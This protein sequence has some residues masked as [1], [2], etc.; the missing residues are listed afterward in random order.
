MS[1]STAKWCI[2]FL[3]LVIWLVSG[4][5]P[6]ETRLKQELA[7]LMESLPDPPNSVLLSEAEDYTS[8]SDPRCSGCLISRLY[9]TNEPIE[10]IVE[11]VEKEILVQ[12]K[13]SLDSR[14]PNTQ[15]MI[16]LTHEGGYRLG[17][18]AVELRPELLKDIFFLHKEIS[19]DQPYGTVYLFN[20]VHIDP[21]QVKHCWSD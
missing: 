5:I 14:G 16:G 8:G 11:F 17:V 15:T 20:V 1:G 3:L 4:C 12:D 10:T 19:L 21:S 18:N 7:S 9:G 2:P 13:W 6:K